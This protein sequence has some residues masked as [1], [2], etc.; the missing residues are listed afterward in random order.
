MHKHSLEI[1]IVLQNAPYI[2]N[3]KTQICRGFFFMFFFK[4]L[5]VLNSG[6]PGLCQRSPEHPL[7]NTPKML[8]EMKNE[9]STIWVFNFHIP[10]IWQRIE[11]GY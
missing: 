1:E 7:L 6:C 5:W 10:K 9:K 11:N 8:L 2:W 3:M 4:Q